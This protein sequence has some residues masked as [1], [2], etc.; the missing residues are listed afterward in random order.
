MATECVE[1]VVE[2][3]RRTVG[4]ERTAPEGLTW[5]HVPDMITATH[6]G[7]DCEACG[8]DHPD[9]ASLVRMT[10]LCARLQLGGCPPPW[11]VY[12]F[13]GGEVIAEWFFDDYRP[14]HAGCVRASAYTCPREPTL[15][16]MM[17]SRGDGHA[18]H[19]S[20]V[21]LLV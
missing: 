14:G 18:H 7:S 8:T 1:D 19:T 16:E 17:V 9:P 6:A 5:A 21:K 4:P 12:T 15:V 20:F 10:A 3:F 13:C 11:T 2:W